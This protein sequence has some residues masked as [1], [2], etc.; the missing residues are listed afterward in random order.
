MPKE[1]TNQDTKDRYYITSLIEESL[2]SSQ[3]EGALVTRAEASEMIREKRK[4]TNEH[5]TMVLNNFRTMVQMEN[6]HLQ[7][8]SPELILEIHRS[9]TVGTLEDPAHVGS[10][11]TSDDISIICLLYTSPSPRDRG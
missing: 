7:E 4:P 11:R 2:T 5:E 8:L 6:W 1:V 3:L 9:I 10:F